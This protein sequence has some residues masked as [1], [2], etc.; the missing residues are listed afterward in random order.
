[1]IIDRQFHNIKCDACGRLID[2]ETWW[3]DKDA[4][5]TQ[6]LNECNWIA[7][8]GRHYCRDRVQMGMAA[9]AEMMRRMAQRNDEDEE[10]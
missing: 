2:D 5:T 4:L 1:M 10:D 9:F 8:E 7:C 3:D 6:I